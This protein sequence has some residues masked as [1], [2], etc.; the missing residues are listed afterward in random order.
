MKKTQ[1]L[2]SQESELATVPTLSY[3]KRI[4]EFSAEIVT[5]T[6]E[7]QKRKNKLLFGETL[8]NI[9]FFFLF[10]S[11]S[12]FWLWQHHHHHHVRIRTGLGW[13]T[14]KMEVVRVG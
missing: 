11:C 14:D 4:L 13:S 1:K 6:A 3:C 7:E 2:V 12:F 8:T 9:F 10:F 5:R